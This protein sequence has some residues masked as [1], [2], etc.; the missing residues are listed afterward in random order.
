MA[1]PKIAILGGGI[2]ALTAA[3]EITGDPRWR[4]NYESVTVYQL[5]W[6]L[7]GKCAS[8]R[9]KA[10][11][12]RIEEHGLHIFLGFYDNAF[13]VVKG[14]YQELGRKP[15]SPLATWD[16]AFKP[17]SYIVLTEK[18]AS[19]K[20]VNWALDFPRTSEEPGTGGEL[21]SLWAMI[22]MLIGWLRQLIAR[23]PEHE[24]RAPFQLEELHDAARA[25]DLEKLK[26][27]LVAR[28]P[29]L[30][31][32]Q[33]IAARAE[34]VVEG[35]IDGVAERVEGLAEGAARGAASRVSAHA[36][37]GLGARLDA[38]IDRAEG[39]A[40]RA[41]GRLDELGAGMARRAERAERAAARVA[42]RV[43][44]KVEGLAE[45]AAAK[46]SRELEERLEIDLDLRRIFVSV[47]L[48]MAAMKGLIDNGLVRWGKLPT[49]AEFFKLDGLDFRVWLQKYGARSISVSSAY[50]NGIYDL[51]F[52]LP[53]EVGAG[54]AVN[55]TLRMVFT[56]KGAVMWKMQAGMGDTIFGPFYE[57]LQR[58]GV[59]FEFFSR[60]DEL[61]LSADKKQIERIVI[62]RQVTLKDP[63]KGYR[64]LVD[65]KGLPCWPSE[66][67]YDQLV[68][69]EELRA[70]GQSL[71]DWWTTWKDPA[72][73]AIL[74]RGD[75]FDQVIL[76][77]SVAIL[78]YIAKQ[79]IEASP[80]FGDM[81]K[82]LGTRQTQA[83]QL[84]MSPDLKGLGWTGQSPVL[85]GYVEPLDTW[86]DMSNLLVRESWPAGY[87][88]KN[89]AYLVGG[90]SDEEPLPPRS[91]HGYTQRQEER[92]RADAQRWLETAAAGLWPK[93]ATPTE[94]FN[95]S[96]LMGA[97]STVHGPARLDS[98]YWI[99]VMN[100]SDR[101]V[102]SLPNTVDKRLGTDGS[103]FD[104]LLLAGDWLLTGISAGSVEAATMGGML[105]SQKLCGRP[106]RI[107][108]GLDGETDG[109]NG[110]DGTDGTDGT[111]DSGAKGSSMNLPNYIARGGE[112]VMAPPLALR[113]TTM[114]SFLVSADLGALTRM[115]DAQLN[116]VSAAS[117]T[118]YKPL[119]PMVA[120]VC[121]GANDSCSRTPPD[122]QK[123]WM[124]ERDFG[125]WVPVVA[126][127]MENGR[128]KPR[129]ICWYLPYVFV[130]NVAAM[131]TG[132]EV[133]G[134]FKQMAQL[135]MP[136]TPWSRGMFSI[137]ALVIPKF[138]PQSQAEVLR[139]MTITSASS[140]GAAPA[141]EWR[142][143]REVADALWPEL[144]R[145]LFDGK[146]EVNDGRAISLW[147]LVKELLEM[148]LTG[149]VPLVFLKQ[150]RAA[151][152][153]AKA[154]YQAVVEA[155]AHLERLYA[156][157]F[158]HPHDIV[159][160]PVDSH[161]IAAECGLSGNRIRSSLGFWVKMDFVMQPGTVIASTT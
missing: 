105:A 18:L 53:G 43:E 151:G 90:L 67:D 66:P 146:D 4:D 152:A 78:P 98:Q 6:R 42:E 103:G 52:S 155:P 9:N 20:Y 159:I 125:I 87:E 118:V 143:I 132:R 73:P 131:V 65:V 72:P 99:A 1:K 106:A 5:G 94:R 49:P 154:C 31:E 36:E 97:G 62:G 121:A 123:G 14:C 101:Y 126:G 28:H 136:P 108:G 68:E 140:D 133:Y 21:P 35:V 71:E 147:E 150:F 24:H 135:E 82:A 74:K 122:S 46:L 157:W 115:I 102:L 75:D 119:F 145:L 144:K 127:E 81:V 60:V 8:G 48:A 93:A 128:W 107:I 45:E 160:T 153:E 10:Q 96:M 11:Y 22:E 13:R 120:V 17:H 57:V 15:G 91:A 137:D 124:G 3:L 54:T 23:S 85:D 161:P 63:A 51:G 100:P 156:G 110:T 12:D 33:G 26:A 142:T 112:L 134:F 44:A 113:G 95:W 27:L 114:Y 109:T 41:E 77:C 25:R 34:G 32:I 89:L 37:R 58:R 104:N 148:M 38:L 61:Q 76:G 55:G 39:L 158:T 116:A 64:P 2:A 117:G 139:L 141:G 70:S 88:P 84:W 130:D 92:V 149:D 129:R 86:A 56:Y 40:G 16:E 69:G 138:T 7:G 79:L 50:I 47:D 30:G 59:R 29:L 111:S 19:G 83:V 80:P